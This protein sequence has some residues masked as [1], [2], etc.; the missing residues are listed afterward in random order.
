MNRRNSPVQ[1][2]GVC[3]ALAL[4]LGVA[5]AATAAD[6][7]TAM[8]YYIDTDPGVGNGTPVPALDGSYSSPL[9][10]GQVSVDTTGLKPGPHQVYVRAL[11]SNGV[12]GTYPPVLLNVH[13]P[14]GILETEWFVDTDPGVGSGT[15]LLA[16]DGWFDQQ[17]ERITTSFSVSGLSLGAHTL[18]LRARN[19]NGIWGPARAISIEV[20]APV[21]VAAAECGIGGT[22]DLEPTFGTYAM[23]AVDFSFNS[24]VEQVRKNGAAAPSTVGTYRAFVR[25]RNDRNMWGPW[26]YVEFTVGTDAYQ[27]WVTSFGLPAGQTDPDDDPDADG[28]PNLVEYAF[29]LLPDRPDRAVLQAGLGT[30]GLPT[31]VVSAGPRLELEFLRRRDDPALTYAAMFCGD[32]ATWEGATQ[33]ESVTAIDATWERVRI[34]DDPSQLGAPRRFGKVDV[35]R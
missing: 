24:T 4:W 19:T 22:S 30:A 21:T 27:A 3:R 25:A 9:E 23:Q 2:G 26:S 35:S 15:P 5:A 16:T 18:Y 11:Q 31:A 29:N 33:P 32:L 34:P 13:Q 14:A 6:T 28:L 20:I 17:S 7:I 10:T 1:C 12:W 8:E